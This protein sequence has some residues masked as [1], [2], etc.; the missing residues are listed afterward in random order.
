MTQLMAFIRFDRNNEIIKEFLFCKP[1]QTHTTPEII[2][3]TIH[4]YLIEIDLPWGK[5]AGFYSD[6]AKAMT[7]WLTGVAVR[8]KK[9]APLCKTMHCLIYRQAL[10]SKNMPRS[11]KLVLDSAI[12]VVKVIKARPLN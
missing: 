11:L 1:L 12:K 7:G 2:F 4:D 10:A 6:G 9:I 5:C 8:T 3:K